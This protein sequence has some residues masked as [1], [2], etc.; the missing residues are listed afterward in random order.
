MGSPEE[1]IIHLE[2][3]ADPNE[4]SWKSVSPNCLIPEGPILMAHRWAQRAE[5]EL[6]A[7]LTEKDPTFRNIDHQIAQYVPNYFGLGLS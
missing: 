5:K 7:T 1:T 4:Q 3:M 6:Q 2:V